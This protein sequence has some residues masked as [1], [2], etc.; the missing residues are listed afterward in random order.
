[1]AYEV[2]RNP[3]LQPSLTE[4]AIKAVEDLYNASKDNEN[5]FFIMVEASRIDHAGHSNDAVAHL[6]DIIEYNNVMKALREWID[7]H[8]NS[9]TTLISTADHETGGL[10]VGASDHSYDPRHF[11]G[12]G[13]TAAT[14]ASKWKSYTGASDAQQSFVQ[15]EIFAKY[16]VSKPTA[17]EVA[18][19]ISLKTNSGSF[20]SFLKAALDNRLHIDWTTGG[21]TGVD[22]TLYGWGENHK[23]FVG[24][25]ENNEVGAFITR[26]LGLDLDGVTRTLNAQT[27]WIRKTVQGGGSSVRR[28]SPQDYHHHHD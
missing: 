19:A 13:A 7:A 16:G 24:N 8:H 14:L 4:M 1:M 21:H 18:Q 9:P 11:A 23:E 6:G 22:V 26:L 27:E 20:E 17:D 15:E 25:H 3:A 5:G 2:E 28:R 12:A 10:T